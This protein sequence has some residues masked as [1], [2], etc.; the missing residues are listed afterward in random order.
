ML[1]NVYIALGDIPGEARSQAL[2]PAANA[3]DSC[4]WE[5]LTVLSDSKGAQRAFACIQKSV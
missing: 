2:P 4:H 3:S 1:I 5:V